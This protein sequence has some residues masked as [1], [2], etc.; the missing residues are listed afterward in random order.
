VFFFVHVV[1]EVSLVT[2]R[3]IQA[4]KAKTLIVTQAD[5]CVGSEAQRARKDSP[6]IVVDVFS[7]QVDT[8]GSV[9]NGD[10]AA[11]ARSEFLLELLSHIHHIWILLNNYYES[12]RAML[13]R[14]PP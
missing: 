9:V 13:V 1:V 11:A 12:S 5:R 8:S 7:D 2:V 14:A 6:A 10:F 3:E 4:R